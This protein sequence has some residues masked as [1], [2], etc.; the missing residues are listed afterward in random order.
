MADAPTTGAVSV[1]NAIA[2]MPSL[3][4]ADVHN[5]VLALRLRISR[6]PLTQPQRNSV[7]KLLG[8]TE[9]GLTGIWMEGGAR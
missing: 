3:T 1:C 9:A 4:T 6:T 7:A 2:E 5:I 8:V